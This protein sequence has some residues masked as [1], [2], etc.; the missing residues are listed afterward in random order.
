MVNDMVNRGTQSKSIKAREGRR[1]SN[2]GR[3]VLM[4]FLQSKVF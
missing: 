3:A 2:Q 1:D 4:C